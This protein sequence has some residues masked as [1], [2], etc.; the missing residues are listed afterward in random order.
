MHELYL[1]ESILRIIDDYAAREPFQR[2]TAINLACGRLS[3]VVPE[4][5]DFAFTVQAQGTKAQG[6]KI[7][8]DILPATIHCF[9]CDAES[10]IKQF[11]GLCPHCNSEEVILVRGTEEL[12]F[13][14]MEVE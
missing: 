5:L 8:I 1:A 10:E 6:A 12:A 9:A 13:I 2:V 7:R 14:D 4:A 11:E 3:S